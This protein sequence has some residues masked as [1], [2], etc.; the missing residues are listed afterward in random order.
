MEFRLLGPEEVLHEGQ[1][2]P[3]SAAKHRAL[4]TMFLL[5]SDRVVMTEDLIDGL[6]GTNPPKTARTTLHNYIRRLRKV[7][8]ACGSDPLLTEPGGYVLRLESHWLDVHAFDDLVA[9]AEGAQ[10]RGDLVAASQLQ[11]RALGLW[12]GKALEGTASRYLAEVEAPRLEEAR[13]SAFEKLMDIDLRLGRHNALLGEM[14]RELAREPLRERLRSQYMLAL[15][16]A[17]RRADALDVYREGRRVLVKE[18]GLEPGPA[19]REMERA[20]LADSPALAAPT[21]AASR[22][23]VSRNA[24]QVPPPRQLPP[25]TA[26]FTGRGAHLRALDEWAGASGTHGPMVITAIDGQGG[27]GKTALAVHWGHSARA[28]YPDGQLYIDMRG[29]A[30]TRPVTSVEALAS[31]LY[32]L[33]IPA[34]RIPDDPDRAAGLYRTLLAEKRVLV[35]IDNARS[36]D[37]V[38][39]L[40]PGTPGSH[41][42]VTSR[43][44]LAG[45]VVRDSARHLGVDALAPEE[46]AELLERLLGASVV[47]AEPEATA[48]LARLCWYVPLALRVSAVNVREAGGDRPVAGHVDRLRDEDRRLAALS[49]PDDEASNLQA[50]LSLSYLS[51]SPDERRL[52]RRLGLVPGPT[53]TV[54]GASALLGLPVART[55]QL[56]RRLVAVHLVG[57]TDPDAYGLHDLL[58]LFAESNA[59][60]DESPEE[61]A[62]ALRRL[63]DYYLAGVRAGARLLYPEKLR[64]FGPGQAAGHAAAET[65]VDMDAGSSR[66]A[67]ESTVGTVVLPDETAARQWFRG[68]HTNLVIAAQRG[69]ALGLP[70]ASWELC[71]G[72]RGYFW[73]VR[74]GPDWVSVAEAGLEAAQ[75][76]NH[77]IGSAT[78]RMSLGD[79][80]RSLGRYDRAA[81]H[82]EALLADAE[83]AHW[84]EGKAQALNSLGLVGILTGKL[85]DAVQRYEEAVDALPADSRWNLLR[86]STEGNMGL[87]RQELGDLRQAERHNA[88]AL[89]LSRGIGSRGAEGVTLGNLGQVLGLLGR[90]EEALECLTE[91]LAVHRELGNRGSEAETLRGL[92]DWH[93]DRGDHSTA[94]DLALAAAALA[95][96]IEESRLAAAALQTVASVRTVLGQLAEA[97]EIYRRAQDLA[98]QTGARHTEAAILIGRAEARLLRGDLAEADAYVRHALERARREGYGILEGQALTVIGR[99]RLAEGRPVEAAEHA[100]HAVS[101][102]AEIGHRTGRIAAQEV[103]SRARS[104]APDDQ[105][106]ESGA[107]EPSA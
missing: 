30:T 48:E 94:L 75:G 33:G 15:Y 43:D 96:E 60:A 51:L 73:L 92:A 41:V 27:M 69:A 13:R 35:V 107:P 68:E 86:L 9:Q 45:L 19:L 28:R 12:R 79:A 82:Y 87:L 32:A 10:E 2:V 23:A 36:A 70:A 76:A 56:L 67:E 46:A 106:E 3:I 71:D 1:P 54:A 49:V 52:F 77:T 6:W 42:V 105:D 61:R 78:A 34:D 38:R 17:G 59:A 93:R 21:A 4:L 97:E 88:T 55:A 31:F 66:G 53:I 91:A 81:Q 72:L 74:T 80:H 62:A 44:V 101:I 40:L 24:G 50:V 100:E 57:Q 7:L 64:A 102:L 39:P 95:D 11:R 63:Y 83:S 84:A 37:Q 98:E 29:Y 65:A 58:R 104:Q 47:A 5:R 18:L 26:H 14:R 8:L 25:G 103:L 22:A 20:I 99:L 89:E 85:R 16:R 90:S